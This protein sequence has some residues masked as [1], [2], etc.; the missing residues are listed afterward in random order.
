MG[1]VLVGATLMDESIWTRAAGWIALV[2]IG[3]GAIAIGLML[4]L[5]G[6]EVLG[7]YGLRPLPS[8]V[9][10]AGLGLVMGVGSRLAFAGL[11]SFRRRRRAR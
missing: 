8:L 10:G 11:G 7:W 2:M 5:F 9:L 3:L 4:L 1:D 6:W